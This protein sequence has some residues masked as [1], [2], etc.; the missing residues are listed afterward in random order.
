M[1]V[2]RS[3]VAPERRPPRRGTARRGRDGTYWLYLIPG[4]VLFALVIGGPLLFTGYLS[5][6]RWS[7]IGDPSFVGLENYRRL[8]DDQVFWLSF[9]NTLSMIVAMVLVPTAL[10]LLLATV[11]FD[12]IG[13]RFRPRTAAA[14]RAAFYLPQV[15]PVVVA[16][17][18]WGWILR[19]DGALNGLLTAVGLDGL[20]H[21]WLGDP[22]TALPAVLGV[23]IWVQIGYPVVVFMAA[24]QRVDPEL[25]EAAEL[26]GAGWWHRF[27]A[28]TLPQ[29]RPETFVVALTCTI[30]AMKVFGPIYALTRGGPENATIVPSYFAY[31]TFFNKLQVGYGSAIS[32][33][34]TAIIVLVA[35]VVLAAQRRAERAD[36][37][38]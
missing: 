2:P 11:L 37:G 24:L 8:L 1:A 36:G 17:I 13:R 10:G 22:D 28:I 31:H 30:A 9:R 14:L 6:T 29:I 5:L 35:L 7:G 16:G 34:L 12:T 18:V 26:D 15:L 20:R 27:R 38:S 32:T 19:P 25:Y 3:P 4:A 33:V 21:D 23:M